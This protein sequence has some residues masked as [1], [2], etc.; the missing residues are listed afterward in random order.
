[1]QNLISV[2]FSTVKETIG[3]EFPWCIYF[4]QDQGI[5]NGT[6][7]IR[8]EG[9]YVGSGL[10]AHEVNGYIHKFC[11]TNDDK[12]NEIT[13]DAPLILTLEGSS[14][15]NQDSTLYPNW[16]FACDGRCGGDVED[17][18]APAIIKSTTEFTYQK[19]NY[20]APF[21]TIETQLRRPEDK[22]HPLSPQER[23]DDLESKEPKTRVYGLP[24]L[25]QPALV[26][27]TPTEKQIDADGNPIFGVPIHQ[28]VWNIEF[29][30]ACNQ[31]ISLIKSE[32]LNVNNK[33]IGKMTFSLDEISEEFEEGLAWL[34]KI[35]GTEF[36]QI[37]VVSTNCQGQVMAVKFITKLIKQLSKFFYNLSKRVLIWAYM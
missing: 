19:P 33:V 1:M 5:W 31:D 12:F 9:S 13:P 14:W 15:I 8:R 28:N 23:F 3:S 32:Q 22:F 18:C 30:N 26:R 21:D 10:T 7:W 16:F 4:D 6:E 27:L 24:V 20:V 17:C 36:H 34:I 35:T 29:E 37:E 11:H 25:P 2:T